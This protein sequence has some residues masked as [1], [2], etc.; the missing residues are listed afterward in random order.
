MG[1]LDRRASAQSD[2]SGNLTITFP[3]VP[4]RHVWTG[5]LRVLSPPNGS[6]WTGQ[7]N[8]IDWGG[9]QVGGSAGVMEGTEGDTISITGTGFTATTTYTAAFEGNDQLA[10]EVAGFFSPFPGTTH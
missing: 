9:T 3:S 6:S 5:T 4:F 1:R 2:G 10:S 7:R 8:G